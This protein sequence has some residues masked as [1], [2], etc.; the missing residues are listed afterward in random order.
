VIYNLLDHD[1]ATTADIW[2]ALRQ[3]F[4]SNSDARKNSLHIELRNMAQGHTPVNLF[5]QRIKAIGDEL[6]ELGDTVSDSQLINIVFVGL[7]KSFD[8]HASFIQMMRPP[9]TFAEV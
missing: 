2:A 7:N 5:C 4:Q 3:L 9:P 8:K 6:H 1:G